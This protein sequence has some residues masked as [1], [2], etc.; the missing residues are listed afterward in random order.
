VDLVVAVAASAAAAHREAGNMTLS[1]DHTRI[2]AA[3]AQAEITT[4]GEI[5]CVIK[6]KA[7]DYPETPLMWAAAIAFIVPLIFL[8]A[9]IWPH[10]WLKPIMLMIFGWNAPGAGAFISIEAII[11]YALMQL[12]LFTATYIFVAIPKVTLWLT[13]RAIIVKRAHKKAMEQFLAQGLHL[14]HERTGVM[15]FC[16][17]EEHF[18][19]IIADEGIYTKV[20]KAVWNETVSVLIKHIKSGDITSGFVAAIE[21]SSHV[22][23]VH[24][25]PGSINPNESPDVLI[26]I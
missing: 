26:E 2:N 22:L 10:D 1:I 15:I 14:T 6:R 16:A 11:F 23:S 25:P 8:G 4:S 9:G 18:V 17:L 19:D 20:D 24:F 5:T 21:K 13:P 12:I 7:L 3:I